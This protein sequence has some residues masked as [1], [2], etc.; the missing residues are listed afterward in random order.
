MIPRYILAAFAVDLT[1]G[2][3]YG[4][5]FLIGH[6]L[7]RLSRFI[8]LDG[9]VNLPTWYSSIQWFCVAALLWVFATRNVSRSKLTSWL[10]L[11]LP[12]VFLMFSLDEVARLHEGFG[13]VLDRS[14]LD[15]PRTST[16]LAKTGT[17]FILL[18]IPFAVAFA[19]LIAAVRPYLRH[20]RGAFLKLV[21]GATMFLTAAIGVE[22]LSNLVVPDSPLATLQILVEESLELIGSTTVLWGCYELVRDTRAIPRSFGSAPE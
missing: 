18:G 16:A 15:V 11:L 1:L 22:A 7:E 4:V 6:P 2:L 17:W 19:L 21:W 12:A 9:E 8:D 14:A 20:S 3:A 10:L 5:D 13:G